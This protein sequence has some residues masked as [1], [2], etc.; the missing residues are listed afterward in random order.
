MGTSSDHLPPC[1]HFFF[2]SVLYQISSL[3]C[4]VTKTE[5]C[6]VPVN[7]FLL[8]MLAVHSVRARKSLAKLRTENGFF[9]KNS[10]TPFSFSRNR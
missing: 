3:K 4:S 6:S 10:K 2:V 9:K 1:F 5:L 7:N 8:S